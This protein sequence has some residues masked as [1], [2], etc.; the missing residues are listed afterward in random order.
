MTIVLMCLFLILASPAFALQV[1]TG[2]YAGNNVDDTDIT[3]SPA[4]QPKAVFVRSLA[5]GGNMHVLTAS[6]PTNSA[7]IITSTTQ[8]NANT[9]QQINAD[10]FEVGTTLNVS[11]TTYYYVCLCDNG[12]QDFVEGTYTGSSGTDNRDITL[13][14]SFTPELVINIPDANGDDVVFRG[15]NSHSGDSS[16][17]TNAAA[18]TAANYIQSFAAGQFQ[19]GSFMNVNLTKYYYLAFKA[20]ASG[21]A[22]GNYAGNTS[23]DRNITVTTFTPEVVWLKGSST[24]AGL[25]HRF[26]NA[27]DSSWC[28]AAAATTN[29]IQAFASGNFQVGTSTCANENTV[30]MRW[31]ALA[32]VASSRR[33]SA[34]IF[35]Q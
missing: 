9:I 26:S 25:A 3:I 1:V 5:G 31:F 29:Q 4:C 32:D 7:G 35:L 34:P 10:G 2:T 20:S 22:T 8:K 24:T 6:M 30:T 17:I 12:A 21:V 11:G 23:D 18:T 27:G 28:A 15:A 14:L 13:S 16:S 19:V 33:P